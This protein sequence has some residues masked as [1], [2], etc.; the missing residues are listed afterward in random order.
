MSEL[1]QKSPDQQSTERRHHKAFAALAGIGLSLL[2]LHAV[3]HNSDNSANTTP[4]SV[5]PNEYE[6]AA[7]DSAQ[8]PFDPETETPVVG[9]IVVEDGDTPSEAIEADP[10]VVE[11]LA[12]NPD[13]EASLQ[14]SSYSLKT[15][16]TDTYTIVERDI[17]SDGDGDAVAV[18]IRK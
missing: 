10:E 18:Q 15:A 7:V 2:S 11:Y 9:E 5:S 3:N 16:D 12:E 17:D 4:T 6:Q 1:T 14:T 8:I 13:E